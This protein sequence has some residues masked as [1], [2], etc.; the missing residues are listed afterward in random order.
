MKRIRKAD[1]IVPGVVATFFAAAPISSQATP[2]SVPDSAALARGSAVSEAA[3][4][5]IK[6]KAEDINVKNALKGTKGGTFSRRTSRPFTQMGQPWIQTVKPAP[7]IKPIPQIKPLPA[8]KPK[9]MT[10]P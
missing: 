6:S 2:A 5:A 7:N 4:D 1:S 3:I 10:R 9:T 8:A